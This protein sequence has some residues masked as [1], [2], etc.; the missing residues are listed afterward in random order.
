MPGTQRT[1]KYSEELKMK[2]LV[3]ELRKKPQQKVSAD[4]HHILTTPEIREPP[5]FDVSPN[6]QSAPHPSFS[7]TSK[8]RKSVQQNLPHEDA[9]AKP[10]PKHGA[11]QDAAMKPAIASLAGTARSVSM[12]KR[13]QPPAKHRSE[14]PLSTGGT[15]KNRTHSQ[16]VSSEK[17]KSPTTR[18]QRSTVLSRGH[19][20]TSSSSD[21][22]AV[23]SDESA[24]DESEQNGQKHRK[25]RKKKR[26]QLKDLPQEQTNPKNRSSGSL[27]SSSASST[28]R[29]VKSV[30]EL[31]EEAREIAAERPQETDH[32][33]VPQEARSKTLVKESGH[34]VNELIASL[35]SQ[36]KSGSPSELTIKEQMRRELVDVFHISDEEVGSQKDLLAKQ[37]V[38]GVSEKKPSS[39]P[40]HYGP[41]LS[42]S[43]KVDMPA[44]QKVPELISDEESLKDLFSQVTDVAGMEARG[45]S[46]A[47][48]PRPRRV[49]QQ[50]RAIHGLSFLATWTPKTNSGEYKTIHH[51]CTTPACQVL[52]VELQ[53]ASSLYHTQDILAASSQ[54]HQQR[55]AVHPV[56]HR[57][58]CEGVPVEHVG[59][60]EQT[61]GVTYLPAQS[62]DALADWQRIAEYYVE[63]PR[64]IMCG[65]A[66]KLC[67][68]QLRMFWSPAPPKF[69]C[70]PC[71]IKDKL[72]PQYQ[73]TPP[74]LSSE[75]VLAGLQAVTESGSSQ[76][77]MKINTAVENILSRKHKSLMDLRA[78]EPDPVPSP[79]VC[80]EQKLLVKRPFSAPHLTPDPN[81]SLRL[82]SDSTTISRE[83]DRVQQQ[84]SLVCTQSDYMLSASQVQSQDT[85]SKPSSPKQ[86]SWDLSHSVSHPCRVRGRRALAKQSIRSTSATQSKRKTS[87][88]GKKLSSAKLA[89]VLKKLRELPRTL[90][91]S[92]SLCEMPQKPKVSAEQT[93]LLRH[94]SLPLLLEFE[95]FTA[96]RGSVPDTLPPQEWVRDIWNT[97]F[98]EV[99]PPREESSIR[100]DQ[101]SRKT[102]TVSSEQEKQPLQNE[103]R[104]LDRVDLSEA[105]DEGLTT[106]DLEREVA[107]LTQ[108]MAEHGRDSAFDLCRRGALYKK[109]GQLSQALEDL[110]A[111][112]SLEPHLLDAYWHRHSIYL[113][114]NVPSSALDDLNFI[115]KHNKKHAD[116]FKS[117]A[118]IYRMRGESNLAII[119]YTQAIKCKPDD[120]E[121]YFRRA[122]MYEKTRE[123][124]LAMEDYAKTF[125]LNP[126]RTDALMAHGLHHFHTSNWRVALEDFTLLLKQE[127]TNARARTYRGKI[128][129]KLGLFQE[130]VE[131]FSLAVHLDPSDWLAFYHRGCLL[132][133]IKPDLALRDFSISVLINDSSENLGAFVHRGLL[134]T[135]CQQWQQAMADF[136]AVI[137]LDRTVAVAHIN[138]GL[139]YMLTMDQNYD[140][141][142]MFSSALKV[143]PTHIRGYICRAR[144]YHKVNDLERALKDL[145]RAIHMR[146]D[147]QHLHI[148]R[149]QCLCDMGLFDLATFCVQYAAEMNKVLG[150]SLV[151]QAAVQ[152]FLRN[153]AKAIACLVSAANSHPSSP[154][155]I[156]LGKTQMKARKFME[157]VESFKKA[158]SFL[159]PPETNLCDVPEA[160]E[161]YYLTGMC[162]MAQGEDSL[163]PQA[164][165]AFSNAVRINPDHADAYHHRGLCRIRLQ[166]SKSVQD[167]NRALYIN[168]NFFQVY[169]SRAAFY[170]AKGR[171]SKAI[172]NCNEAIRIQPKCVRAYLYRGALKFHSKV[173]K[174]AVEDLTMAIKIDSA[175]SFAYYNRGVCYQQLK[176]YELALRDYSIVLLLPSQKEIELK[177]LINRALVYVELDD[178]YNALQDFKAAAMKH[179]E[180][181]SIHHSLG[182]HFHRLGQL[183]EAVEAYS[184]ALR[185]NPF[186]LDAYVG[187]GDVFMDY[188]HAQA[189]KQAQR[190]FL[191]AL[192]LNP[193]CSSARI[194]L[195]YNFQVFGCFK[196]AWNQFTVAVEVNPKCWAAYEGRAIVSLQM[197]N[198]FAAFQ[199]INNA[200]KCNPHSDRLL[201][202][203]GVIN[204]FMGDKPSAMSDYQRAISLN[205]TCA[206][207]FFNAAN[208]FF[209][210]RQFEQACEYYSRAFHLDPSDES[211][212]LNRAITLALLRKIPESLRDF[213]EALNLNPHSAHVYFNRANLY[214]S[215]RKYK[216]AERDYTQALQL[217]PDDA[218]L[219]K[220]RADVHGHLG[221]TEQAVKDYR[222]AVELQEAKQHHHANLFNR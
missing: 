30:A 218:L 186:L 177:V 217:Q 98:D 160:S 195:A 53:R 56:T 39:G 108:T 13:P 69:S 57:V 49:S 45:G 180:D 8:T 173:Y 140:A 99:F 158:L 97:W 55:A 111:A 33:R 28:I 134:Y 73:A 187:R 81:S 131:D 205:P 128:F 178:H 42:G 100:S 115:I 139:I 219:Y 77:D 120:P 59:D 87:K 123:V 179:P 199:D 210:N 164:L 174:G 94:P 161:L 212:I 44:S 7:K 118:E 215:L 193:Q 117:R 185:L 162:Y 109:L 147:A 137:K 92:K 63:K 11:G 22:S 200:L 130:A 190:D 220:L 153:D 124:V 91:R 171:Y 167:F 25:A 104:I 141:I 135:E 207:A 41:V 12:S 163:L 71:V 1:L 90:T 62:S 15:F 36:D 194:G 201:T 46:F 129:A 74:D 125:A 24:S 78:E 3:E 132:R 17:K 16:Q 144:A 209:Y 188:G 176:E 35:Q 198:T 38:E 10:P 32:Q 102:C 68:G 189:N 93:A 156:L 66:A 133:K 40:V 64:M 23:D 148:M 9:S 181:A 103:I 89:Y 65:H 18:V 34:T 184:E 208:L 149:G 88:T 151:Q 114:R 182:V 27:K 211:A 221:L 75:N 70:A 143:D 126:A 202:N 37:L 175:C 127:P 142:K 79:D 168:P 47:L 101:Q 29:S 112:I 159:C 82:Q 150:S 116:A 121:N 83:L 51:L 80:L 110:N 154:V 67:D 155:L 106:A 165:E 214:F 119:N 172:L 196:R 5:L 183:Q 192:H 216:A 54:F 2:K 145:T 122:K 166:Q 6:S 95:V 60:T 52:P 107:K 86:S 19:L 50:P 21:G 204:Q 58:M 213:S 14:R 85:H 72:F 48:V 170:G 136:E 157:A 113:L 152:S 222:T 76:M 169:L 20:L 146:P 191:S 197:G 31:L 84:Q 203:R 206:L 61:G 26:R 4:V 105:L 43:F 96:E 138:L